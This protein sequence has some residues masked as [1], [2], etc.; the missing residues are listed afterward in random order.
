MKSRSKFA[1]AMTLAVATT[2]AH[3]A[4][5]DVVATWNGSTGLWNDPT[6][7]STNP[8]FPNNAGATLYDVFINGGDV[9]LNVSPTVQNVTL[10]NASI[11]GSGTLTIANLLTLSDNSVLTGSGTT[12]TKDL[13]F[14]AANTAISLTSA[15]VLVSTGNA[16]WSGTFGISLGNGNAY[17][18]QGTLTL[19]TA[20][21]ATFSGGTF[22]NVGSFIKAS[23]DNTTISSTFNNTGSVLV[24]A[25]TLLLSGGG[26]A[27]GS[28]STAG[29]GLIQFAGGTHKFNA[30][31]SVAS[32]NVLTFSGGSENFNSGSSYNVTGSTTITAGAVTFLSG[33]TP[34]SFGNTL[35]L[36]G[37]SLT[38]NAIASPSVTNFNF[39]SGT[40]Q[41]SDNF[42]V[43]GTV[44]WAGGTLGG[45]GT[46]TAR[47]LNISL[48]ANAVF[49]STRALTSTGNTTWSGSVG[50]NISAAGSNVYT[51]QGAFAI[52]TLAGSSWSGGTFNNAGTLTKS[53][54]DSNTISAIFNNTGNVSVA[55]G[56]LN[57]GGG[58][59]HTGAFSTSASGLI[60]FSGGTYNFNSGAALTTGNFTFGAGIDNFN[61][62]ATFSASGTTAVSGATLNFLAGSVLASLGS[63]LTVSAG[64]V[65]LNDGSRAD[66]RHLQP[67]RR[68]LPGI[69]QPDRHQRHELVRWHARGQRLN[70]HQRPR[71]HSNRKCRHV[72]HPRARRYRQHHL[73]L[74]RPLQRQPE[75]HEQLYQPG[76]VHRQH[77]GRGKLDGRH[78]QQ[79]GNADQDQHGFQQLHHDL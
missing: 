77:R 57:L 75:R 69:G 32:G 14:N 70:H 18:N 78:V 29:A 61:A 22:K 28:F 47:D 67:G 73:E 17:T 59:T 12:T 1:M 34:T 23:S 74:H 11:S 5:G 50:F 52:N 15:R 37:G 27:P 64:T 60:N 19:N 72:R 21:D 66:R 45:S 39:S 10:S 3:A 53:S 56:T 48:A 62:N 44:T 36:S 54:T 63:T 26:A 49:N 43:T 20:G 8:V 76:H 33:S 16:T 55:A 7:W 9:T 40:F 38:L 58:G 2:I 42:G 35:T 71:H 30:S 24:N 65:N 46:I 13:L 25:G 31:A 51:N 4:K 68:H 6:A 79:P 41:G